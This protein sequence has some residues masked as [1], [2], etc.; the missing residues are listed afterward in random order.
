M[1]LTALDIITEGSRLSASWIDGNKKH[2]IS[3][4]LNY[5]GG[6]LN[7]AEAVAVAVAMAIEM[8]SDH[9]DALSDALNKSA[10]EW[11]FPLKNRG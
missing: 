6:G 2:V 1:A 11:H 3:D 5:G 9:L 8:P 10:P 7:R 4:L